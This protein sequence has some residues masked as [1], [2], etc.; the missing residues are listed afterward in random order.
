MVPNLQKLDFSY[1]SLTFITA[2]DLKI[3]ESSVSGRNFSFALRGNPITC[4]CN[5]L[6]FISWLFITSE[7]KFDNGRNYI[8]TGT[9]GNLTTTLAVH[10]NYHRYWVSCIS[11]TLFTLALTLLCLIIIVFLCSFVVVNNW[12]RIHHKLLRLLGSPY[13]L[14]QRRDFPFAIY[15]GYCDSDYMF[16]YRTI[17]QSLE[18]LGG[19]RL[20]LQEREILPGHGITEG[21]IEGIN[22]SWK[23]LLIV[24]RDFIQD[25]CSFLKIRTCVFA[26]SEATP[27][28]VILLIVG[29]VC[30]AD[31][32]GE[33]LTVV[34]EHDILTIPSTE[35][36]EDALAMITDMVTNDSH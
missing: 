7:S 29:D 12:T 26:V 30:A 15:V 33:I 24:T 21:I 35:A 18:V 27:R 9:D 31:I 1:N 17:Y 6:A 32:P 13:R 36:S 16:V 23:T 4:S 34:H 25:P 14:P 22:T 20:Y 11:P 19:L 3:I 2:D 28:R 10:Q 5:S 8:C